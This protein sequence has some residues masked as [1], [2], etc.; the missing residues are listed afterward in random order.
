M[1]P[2][3]AIAAR[4]SP[5]ET[6]R[7][8]CPLPSENRGRYATSGGP[9]T[10][11]SAWDPYGSTFVRLHACPAHQRWVE[12][13]PAA[14]GRGARTTSLVAASQ[15]GGHSRSSDRMMPSEHRL[16]TVA[17]WPPG[18][19]R[20]LRVHH[21]ALAQPDQPH[22]PASKELL[23]FLNLFRIRCGLLPIGWLDA[24]QPL[25]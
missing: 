23:S 15:S 20:S 21:T 6:N 8:T 9:P 24:R 18:A 2:P 16:R 19:Q 10:T 1:R 25:R 7:C 4:A 17:T 22:Q 11:L 3:F 5:S 14:L 12:A 13:C